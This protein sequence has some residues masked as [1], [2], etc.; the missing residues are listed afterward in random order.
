MPI[1]GLRPDVRIGCWLVETS[2]HKQSI[3]VPVLFT[4]TFTFVVSLL[5]SALGQTHT[6][7]GVGVDQ[8]VPTTTPTSAVT[9]TSTCSCSTALVRVRDG[10]DHPLTRLLDERVNHVDSVH[11]LSPFV[12]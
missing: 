12:D 10:L 7:D 2:H 11:S 1:E 8:W 5:E 9:G 4:F 3:L 6:E